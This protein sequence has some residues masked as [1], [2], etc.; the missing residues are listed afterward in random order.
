MWRSRPG[1]S[2][3]PLPRA[4]APPSQGWY[5]VVRCAQRKC[6]TA[7]A[8]RRQAPQSVWQ[9]DRGNS[10]VA[11]ASDEP[12]LQAPRALRPEPAGHNCP[13]PRPNPARPSRQ[14]ASS[15]KTARPARA[16]GITSWRESSAACR[17][18]AASARTRH[19]APTRPP[20]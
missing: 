11:G 4:D 10:G 3:Y 20:E 7:T 16:A 13:A 15:F 5:E 18:A 19:C 1:W 14:T 8:L 12:V 9:P 17:S 6:K 2:R